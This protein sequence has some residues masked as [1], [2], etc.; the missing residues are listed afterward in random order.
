MNIREKALITERQKGSRQANI[1]YL[2][3]EENVELAI[4][5]VSGEISIST[6]CAVLGIKG[7][8][9]AYSFLARALRLAWMLRKIG[10]I[11]PGQV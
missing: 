5:Y 1:V 3:N 8:T 10:K 2:A 6:V 7:S 9:N 11:D 4:M